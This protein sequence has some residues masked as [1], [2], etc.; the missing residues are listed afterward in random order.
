MQ[1]RDISER[2][3]IPAPFM[4]QILLQLR[5]GGIVRS[6][7]GAAGG[8][9]LARSAE[10][11]GVGDVLRALRG[12]L[13]VSPTGAGESEDRTRSQAVAEFWQRLQES[14]VQVAATATLQSLADRQKALE[15][16]RVPM[17]YI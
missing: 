16:A 17:F 1:S 4:D 14:V 9:L 13:N 11:I 7:R 8:F 10:E 15:D 12:D 6:V 3:N 5:R 2:H